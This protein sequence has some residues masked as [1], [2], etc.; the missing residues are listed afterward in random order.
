MKL[1][2]FLIF[3]LILLSQSFANEKSIAGFSTSTYFNEQ[4]ITFNYEPN[5]RIHINVASVDLFDYSKAVN[6]ALFALPNGNTIEQTIGKQ[7]K[8]GVDWHYNI[9][10]I[11]AQ[12]RW[13]RKNSKNQ[14]LVIAY[15]EAKQ[16]SWPAWKSQSPEYEKICNNLVEYL[17]VIF[18]QTD[19]KVTLTGHSGGGRFIFSF[20]DAHNEI[21]NYIERIC[22]LDSDY[23]YEE[24]YGQKLLKWLNSSTGNNLSIIAYNDSIALYN[25]KPFVSA[26]GGTW[27]RSKMMK[28]FLD[29]H[30]DFQ[31]VEDTSLINHQA[32]DG[33][34][35]IILKKNPRREIYHTVQVERNGFIHTMLTGT[36]YENSGYEYY[37]ERV[38]DEL[39]QEEE[40]A[41][42]QF[43][44][45][46]RSKNF[47]TGSQF[48]ESMKQLNF[49]DREEAIY[50]E[51][52]KGN[53][54]DFLRNFKTIESQFKD[55][56]G[57]IRLVKYEVLPDY[58]AIGCDTN[59]CRIPMGPITGQKIA[60]QFGCLLPTRKLVDNIYKNASVKLKPV[61]YLPK[62]NH[63]ETIEKFIKHNDAI[64]KQLYELNIKP[65][66]LISGIKKDVIISNK[67]S[68]PNRNQHVT[69]YGWHRLNG[70]RIQPIYNGHHDVYVD[71]SH[72]IRLIKNEIF[73]DGNP[74]SVH[75]I[76]KDSVLFKLISDEENP[77]EITRYLTE[78]MWI[79][80]HSPH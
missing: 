52:I 15:L 77:M 37:G 75:E 63:N 51:I 54:P 59:F 20:M 1:K 21:P 76:L 39:I 48:M 8:D 55:N 19:I 29:D 43:H 70:R 32:L 61:S 58:L 5:I 10:N 56:E 80:Q 36:D 64:N 69:I 62:E 49:S 18:P 60:N 65:G 17:T 71:Y 13:L 16:K 31:T 79:D 4:Y 38:Y 67:L 33:R 23:G 46:P 7:M 40:L 78:R 35:S 6:L 53:T 50:Q 44:F 2:K 12:T 72:G 47:Q 27:Y 26:T 42:A 74:F 30:Y 14:N 45:P 11:G 28:D 73:V 66:Q 57:N 24:I 34:I 3:C 25:G 68:D 9:Q 41:N 22:F